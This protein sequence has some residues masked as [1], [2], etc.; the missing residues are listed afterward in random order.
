LLQGRNDAPERREPANVIEA[1]A[2]K[3]VS[4]GC[5]ERGREDREAGAKEING[6][7][8]LGADS[9]SGVPVVL[10]GV[11]VVAEIGMEAAFRCRSRD[12]RGVAVGC[13][14]VGE[15]TFARGVDVDDHP[16]LVQ[17]DTERVCVAEPAGQLRAAAQ[18]RAVIAPRHRDLV[19]AEDLNREGCKP[20]L[21][22]FALPAAKDVFAQR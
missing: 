3:L 6:L 17:H 12:E 7:S 4:P 18:A 1:T 9:A 13:Q 16:A 11:C 15:N 19:F 14:H 20:A 22:V 5:G 2:D 8:G 21:G 10:P